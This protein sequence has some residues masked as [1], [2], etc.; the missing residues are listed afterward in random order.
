M[1]LFLLLSA[2]VLW[3]LTG[4]VPLGGALV[5]LGVGFVARVFGPSF[6]LLASSSGALFGSAALT[7]VLGLGRLDN[8]VYKERR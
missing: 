7:L 1:A 2:L 8:V 4:L 6:G 5:R 3:L